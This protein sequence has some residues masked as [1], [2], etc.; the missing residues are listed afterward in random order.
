[1]EFMGQLE[2]LFHIRIHWYK[3]RSR[4]CPIDG[5]CEHSGLYATI[6]LNYCEDS[7]Q[8]HNADYGTR[9]ECNVF[10]CKKM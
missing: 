4:S 2:Q 6:D 3:K 1:M 9:A 7:N 8:T 10:F 5:F